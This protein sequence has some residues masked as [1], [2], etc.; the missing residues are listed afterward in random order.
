MLG[1]TYLFRRHQ[2]RV[3]HAALTLGFASLYPVLAWHPPLDWLPGGA[4]VWRLS[5]T[6][7]LIVLLALF[8][9]RCRGKG[10]P[11]GRAWRIGMLVTGLAAFFAFVLGGFVRERARQPYN[12]YGQLVKVEVTRSEADRLLV[13]EKCIGC[14]HRSPKDLGRY[15]KRDWET[16]VQR[17]RERPGAGISDEEAARIIMYL[18]EHYR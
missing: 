2:R 6:L 4:V 3:L 14:H 10:K 7:V 8:W 11:D 1:G 18:K 9:S 12:V 15:E 5:Y 16:R 13:Y 17:E